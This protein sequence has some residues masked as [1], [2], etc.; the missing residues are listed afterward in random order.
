MR[1]LFLL[2]LLGCPLVVYAGVAHCPYCQTTVWQDGCAKCVINPAPAYCTCVLGPGS[3][4]QS[5]TLCG[6]C[7]GSYPGGGSYCSEQCGYPCKNIIPGSPT[8]STSSSPTDDESTIRPDFGDW[9]NNADVKKAIAQLSPKMGLAVAHLSV[10]SGK[11]TY[12][13][14]QVRDPDTG[15]IVKMTIAMDSSSKT[16]NI[17]LFD[18]KTLEEQ[19][20]VIH[21]VT[22]H[23]GLYKNVGWPPE[24][25]ARLGFGKF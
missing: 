23:W 5:T 7:D 4:P 10:V 17:E 25:R 1:K 21:N 18:P 14:G 24:E 3:C 2:L 11:C 19:D 8:L 22:R 20:L 13:T 9:V 16:L 6:S 15:N 12:R